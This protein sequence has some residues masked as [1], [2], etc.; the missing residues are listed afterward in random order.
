MGK[1][2]HFSGS[3]GITVIKDNGMGGHMG[4]QMIGHGPTQ[5]PMMGRRLADQ[6][7]Q[8]GVTGGSNQHFANS[9]GQVGDNSIIGISAGMVR[10]KG[11]SPKVSGKD[12]SNR[13]RTIKQFGGQGAQ[14]SAGVG[15]VGSIG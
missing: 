15:G 11:N 12:G 6:G 4:H 10:L 8:G 14:M 3:S 9:Q 13:P 2:S 1:S 5:Q 7:H